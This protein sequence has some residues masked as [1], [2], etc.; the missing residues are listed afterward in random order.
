MGPQVP[1]GWSVRRE[2]GRWVA[3]SPL[4]TL[5]TPLV[6]G[7]RLLLSGGRAAYWLVGDT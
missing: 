2:V 5:C 4:E 1:P 6:W 7:H 3:S